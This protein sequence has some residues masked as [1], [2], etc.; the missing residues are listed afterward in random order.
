MNSLSEELSHIVNPE[1]VFIDPE[2]DI[3]IESSAQNLFKSK[4]AKT[5]N[6]NEVNINKYDIN[7]SVLRRKRTHI[8]SDVNKR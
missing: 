7:I 2:D 4:T 6:E 8:L 1:P 5:D 3:N